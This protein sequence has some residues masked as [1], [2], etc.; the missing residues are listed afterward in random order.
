MKRKRAAGFRE[1][2]ALIHDLYTGGDRSFDV[3]LLGPVSRTWYADIS[4]VYELIALLAALDSS[5]FKVT[6]RVADEVPFCDMV[7]NCAHTYNKGT[8]I[9]MWSNFF[10]SEKDNVMNGV[11]LVVALVARGS[12]DVLSASDLVAEA[13][14][15]GRPV[16]AIYEDGSTALVTEENYLTT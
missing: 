7:V 13:L 12:Q 6:I 5:D 9:L 11:D 10:N 16:L 15:S 8:E 1:V 2:D 14:I 3:L 4:E